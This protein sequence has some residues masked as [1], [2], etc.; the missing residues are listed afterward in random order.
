MITAAKPLYGESAV[1]L[2]LFDGVHLGHRRVLGKAAKC[3][4]LGLVPAAFT[5]ETESFPKKH[6]KPF[7]Y[8]CT[9]ERKQELLKSFGIEYI[10]SPAFEEI[11]EMDGE[12]FCRE[13]L[14]N[15]LHAKKVFCGRDFRF[16][17]NASCGFNELL[18]AGKQMGFEAGLVDAVV[19]DG[20]NVSSTRIRSALKSGCPEKAAELLGSAYAVTGEVVRGK[21][22][23][24]TLNFPTINQLF[25]KGQLVPANGVYLSRITNS[26]GVFYGVTNIGVKPTVTEE[27]IPLSET[28]IFD[29]QGSLYGHS[30]I[31]ELLRFIRPER[32]F[33]NIAA[34]QRAIES[35][36]EKAR[37]L[38]ELYKEGR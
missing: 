2:G 27:N 8:L 19:T 20:E 12:S 21:A 13:I 6:G 15:T 9:D 26:C 22:L 38:A 10:Y 29:F 30:C 34:L 1:A 3:R 23:G 17:R 25:K 4:A 32:K 18:E 11:K 7:E 24:R 35:D 36:T 14:V 33:E 31:T 28:F 5:F 16:G 37:S